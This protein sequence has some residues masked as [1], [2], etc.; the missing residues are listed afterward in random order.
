M[1][2]TTGSNFTV[3]F[4]LEGFQPQSIDVRYRPA[5]DSRFDPGASETAQFIPNPVIAELEPLPPPPR[6]RRRP[7]PRRNPPPPGQPGR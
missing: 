4:S 2:V 5:G 7:P 3:T 6:T 1:A